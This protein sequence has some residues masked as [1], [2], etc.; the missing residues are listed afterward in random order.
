MVNYN[1]IVV[2]IIVRNHDTCA[3][4][5]YTVETKDKNSCCWIP[6]IPLSKLEIIVKG[7]DN[8]CCQLQLSLDVANKKNNLYL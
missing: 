3:K 8:V 5:C 1:N 6:F 2:I 4:I 7:F